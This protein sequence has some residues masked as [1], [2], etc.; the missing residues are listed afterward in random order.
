M[1]TFIANVGAAAFLDVLKYRGPQHNRETFTNTLRPQVMA[2]NP[3]RHSSG[4][5]TGIMIDVQVEPMESE[6]LRSQCQQILDRMYSDSGNPVGNVTITDV[7]GLLAI[8]QKN[9][10]SLAAHKPRLL[11]PTK[12]YVLNQ[13]LTRTPF[14]L[15]NQDTLF[16]LGRYIALVAEVLRSF[17]DEDK[18]IT[19]EH[20]LRDLWYLRGINKLSGILERAID[21]H[22]RNGECEIEMWDAKI[23]LKHC[24]YL[25]LGMND[26]FTVRDRVFKKAGLVIRGILQGYG[27]QYVDAKGTLDEI[28][29]RQ[30]E[31]EP[32]H[33]EYM[34]LEVQYLGTFAHAGGDVIRKG[35]KET[36]VVIDLRD[37]LERELSQNATK[38]S[39]AVNRGFRRFAHKLGQHWQAAGPYEENDHYFEYLLLALMYKASFYL[40]SRLTCFGE[41][42][43]AIQSVL[44]WSHE[45]ADLL[46]LKATDLYERIDDLGRQDRA[47][48]IKEEQRR[49]IEHWINTHPKSAEKKV[50]CQRYNSD[51]QF[52]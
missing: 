20:T 10:T 6:V 35:Q 7:I 36:A 39:S 17:R 41:M 31:R 29:Q 8:F 45:S 38:H 2:V 27:N 14:H 23:T 16:D 5:V 33:E 21:L 26:S 32:W 24:Q 42:V 11:V 12:A 34:K 52:N 48:Y 4:L 51:A 50:N 3:V 40:K 19:I 37:A 46:H 1:G 49:T 28:L 30:R 44:K 22:E 15:F 9:R 47:P 25:L 18:L 43:G 13:L